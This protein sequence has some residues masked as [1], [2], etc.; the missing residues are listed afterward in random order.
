[1]EKKNDIYTSKGSVEISRAYSEE[2]D[3]G[4]FD[5]QRPC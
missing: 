4:N 1:M 2:R 3:I 5:T